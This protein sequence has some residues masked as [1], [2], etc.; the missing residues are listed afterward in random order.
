MAIRDALKEARPDAAGKV[1]HPPPHM[2]M[3]GDWNCAQ[4]GDLQFARNPSCRRCGA[5]RPASAGP[6]AE[7][8]NA[9]KALP[10]DW[11]CT[12]C[13]DHQFARNASCRRC[14]RARPSEAPPMLEQGKPGDWIC[15]GCGDLQVARNDTCKRCGSAKPSEA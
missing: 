8:N 10:G 9:Q 1:S 13:G 5:D 6:I 15:H 7:K 14:G 3:P 2:T 12:G 4:C 11:K